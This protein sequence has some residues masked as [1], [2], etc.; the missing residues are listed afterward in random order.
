MTYHN[1]VKYIKTAPLVSES[2]VPASERMHLLFDILGNPHRK[3]KYI[4]LA[5]SNGKTLC[6][7][8]L[9]SILKKA[10]IS[11][12]YL[13]MRMRGDVRTNVQINTEP[14]SV[15]ETAYY[16]EKVIAAV[17]RINDEKL[18]KSEGEETQD[19]QFVLTSS[20]KLLAMGLLAFS[21]RDCRLCI[22]ESDHGGSDPSLFMP[23][24][25]AAVVCGTI[26]SGDK[27][28]IAKIRAYITR[29][30]QEIVSAP[31][32]AEAH[33]VLSDTCSTVNCRL[34]LALKSA[35]G[36]GK[37]TLRNTDFSYKGE[38]YTLNLCGKFQ[39]INA[40]VALESVEMLVRR[41]FDI[42]KDAIH[43]GLS[44]L[45]IHSKFEVLSVMPFIVAD[46]TH[47]P[48]AIDTVCDSMADFKEMTG[49][50]IRL[51]LPDGE[52]ITQYHKALTDR[53]YEVIKVVTL[54]K[55]SSNEINDYPCAVEKCKTAK[56]AVRAS[57][58][59]LSNDEILLLSGPYTFTEPLRYEL[60]RTL[61]Y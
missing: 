39:I 52:L 57:L 32:N 49:T 25:F 41:G 43:E 42:P 54:T 51:C 24:P 45:R 29:G 13:A 48:I 3:L 30:V 27:K 12:G 33:R 40:T 22:I 34:T 59:K 2:A 35:I 18:F 15:A 61:E 60:V 6:G 17:A 37:L 4:R 19:E 8:M 53:G 31:Q 44:S 9:S 58:S 14:L 36:V 20:E 11:V 26:P 21:E 28:E 56:T 46:S 5:G 38:Q 1:A 10:D 55:E 7:A 23:A 16:A 50:K 47:T